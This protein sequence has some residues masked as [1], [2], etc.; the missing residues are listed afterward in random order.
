[1]NDSISDN[2]R[3]DMRVEMG[4]GGRGLMRPRNDEIWGELGMGIVECT[5]DR[6]VAVFSFLCYLFAAT[7]RGTHPEDSSPLR[8]YDTP[9]FFF[10]FDNV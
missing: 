3:A 5:M 7:Q 1:M 2:V 4:I 8:S 6:R 10:L 9:T